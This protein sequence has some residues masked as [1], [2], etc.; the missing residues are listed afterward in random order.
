MIVGMLVVNGVWY[1]VVVFGSCLMLFV[2]VFVDCMDFEVWLV[3]DECVVVFFV[4]GLVK[5]M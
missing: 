2:L 5:L 3:M 1:V 4:F